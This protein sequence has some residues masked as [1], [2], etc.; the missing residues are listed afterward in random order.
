M[1]T[2]RQVL[3]AGA[4]GALDIPRLHAQTKQAKIGVLGARSMAESVYAGGIVRSF[5][6]LGYRNIEYRSA[7]GF[8]ERYPK[9]ARELIG[10]KCALIVAFG[11]EQPARALQDAR[12][13]VPIV[14]L[15]VDYDPVEK[16][17]VPS[18]R[19]PD[20]N[21]TGVYLPQHQMVAKRLE[22][23]REVLPS[24]QRFLVIAD[25]FSRD[26]LA[27]ARSAAKATGIRLTV[28]EFPGQPYDY[29]AAFEAARK[30]KAEALIGLA[31]P[32][33]AGDA[34]AISGLALKH[35]LPSI[36]STTQQAAK[37]YL[38][39]FSADVAKATRRVAAIGVRI[40]S[41]SKPETIPVEQA[42]EFELAVNAMTVRALGLKI[43]ESVMARATRI[44]Q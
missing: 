7:D 23:M 37:G 2:R 21:T 29:P 12:S 40:L 17:I 39:S 20:R 28:I 35:R 10:L 16:A 8:P 6:E 13:P 1:T 41:G 5:A 33:F 36:G 3:L 18:L 32:V 22:L 31:S 19:S 44:V 26:Q 14:I 15:A 30:E 9:L 43:P 34:S 11:P 27:A 42:D 38:L 24:A 25:V 4:L